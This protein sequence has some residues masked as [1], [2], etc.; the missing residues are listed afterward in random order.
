MMMEGWKEGMGEE[1]RRRRRRRRRKRN[2]KREK[3]EGKRQ[4]EGRLSDNS[5]NIDRAG[6]EQQGK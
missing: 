6:R 5:N 2:E 3:R 1:E 4:A